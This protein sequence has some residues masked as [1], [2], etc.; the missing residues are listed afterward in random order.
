M[1][2]REVYEEKLRT[3][4]LYHHDPTINP[5]LGS[6]R[7]PRCLSL[8]NPS[9]VFIYYYHLSF[10]HTTCL[11]ECLLEYLIAVCVFFRLHVDAEQCGMDHHFCFTWCHSC[12]NFFFFLLYVSYLF[13][14]LCLCL[15]FWQFVL[16]SLYFVA[17]QKMEV[18]SLGPIPFKGLCS[19]LQKLCREVKLIFWSSSMF[20]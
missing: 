1:G 3:G 17:V 19:P 20:N 16:V 2:T 7:C 12:G 4:N 10:F 5:G 18:V 6:P 11:M 14:S 9:P 15:E 13:T 8:L